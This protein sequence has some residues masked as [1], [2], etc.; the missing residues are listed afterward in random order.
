M[1][2]IDTGLIGSVINA[3]PLDR[4]ISGPLQ[5]MITAQV[6]ASKAYADF[7][8]AVCIKDGKAVS[9]Q[10]DY[11]E[12][13]VDENGVYKGTVTKKMRIPLLAAI[14]HPNITIEEGSID[15]ELTISQQ[16]EDTSE[17][18]GE[19]SFEAKLGWGP[20]SVTVKGSVSHKSTQTRKTDTRARYAIS[21]KIARQDP[22]E[23]LMRVIDFL[24][25][26]ATKPVLLPAQKATAATDPLPTD[27]VLESPKPAPA[28]GGTTPP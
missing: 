10:F 3:L 25:D 2:Q 26:A 12:T 13:L 5:A 27:A 21:T 24:T 18:A 8:M 6:Q 23:A 20:L 7:L 19:G 16:A 11:D 4:M 9:V 14:S 1:S 17:T 22:P 28:K 15:F